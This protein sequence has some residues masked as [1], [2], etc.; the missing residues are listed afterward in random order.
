MSIKPSVYF[1]FDCHHEQ[2][3]EHEKLSVEST[4]QD[5]ICE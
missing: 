3:R 1:R 4:H 2:D 5:G